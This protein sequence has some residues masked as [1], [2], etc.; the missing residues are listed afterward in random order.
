MNNL[1]KILKAL[2]LKELGTINKTRI[3]YLY[4]EKY[5]FSFDTVKNIGTF[6]EIE[7]IN[8]R[9]N[10]EKDFFQLLNIL[11]ELKIDLNMIERKK[12]IDYIG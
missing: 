4:K 2:G 5:E 6:I 11:E 9:G 7:L 10:F 12:Y 1:N 8:K 3:S